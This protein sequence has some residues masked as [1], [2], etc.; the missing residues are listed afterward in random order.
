[1][2]FVSTL[3][4]LVVL[5]PLLAGEK[6]TAAAVEPLYRAHVFKEIPSFNPKVTFVLTEVHIPGLWEKL[7]VQIFNPEV[8][9]GDSSNTREPIIYHEGKIFP[10]LET[11]GTSSLKSAFVLGDTLYYTYSWGSGIHRSL[12]GRLRIVQGKPEKQESFPYLFTDLFVENVSGKARVVRA[13]FKG[14]NLWAN[15]SAVGWV[16]LNEPR[17][18]KVIDDAGRDVPPLSR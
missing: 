11:T 12:V 3:V 7:G 17:R 6:Q 10:L 5:T 15:A 9:V 16:D 18:L 14:F 2:R 4:A 13:E 8:I 1:M